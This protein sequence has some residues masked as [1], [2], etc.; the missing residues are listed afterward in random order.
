[1]M[2]IFEVEK[3]REHAI[4]VRRICIKLHSSGQCYEKIANSHVPIFIRE[5][6]KTLKTTRTMMSKPAGGPMF[7]WKEVFTVGKSFIFGSPSIHN[8]CS[9]LTTCELVIF[10]RH[11]SSFN[12]C[13]QQTKKLKGN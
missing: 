2:S 1:M 8:N 3:T 12:V 4:Q 11:P 13:H 10:F 9:K 7:G 5:I 6:T